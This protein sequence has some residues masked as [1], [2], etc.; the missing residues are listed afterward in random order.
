MK[1]GPNA[2]NALI[3]EVADVVVDDVEDHR[4]A[5]VMGRGDEPRQTVRPAVR[6]L[7]GGD[8]DA[9]VAPPARARELGHRH[10]LDRGD[11]EL[12]QLRAGARSL[13]SN[14]PSRVNVPTW[15]S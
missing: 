10:Q 13:P 12:R 3:P 7:R 2:S 15:S 6:G 8:V 14:V 11:P 4:E 1:Y 9:V 5:D